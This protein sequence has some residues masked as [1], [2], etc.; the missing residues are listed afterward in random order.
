MDLVVSPI[1]L[2]IVVAAFAYVVNALTLW[3]SAHQAK[4]NDTDYRKVL[5]ELFKKSKMD[6]VVS[7]I[8]VAIVVAASAY[9][10]NTLTLWESAHQAKENDT[11][12]M[13]CEEVAYGTATASEVCIRN[14]T[15]AGKYH[16][17]TTSLF[18]VKTE[19]L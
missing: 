11:V 15:Y 16:D 18:P 2:A 7:P 14:R 4:E 12:Y 3:E 8:F 9:V 19:Q 1:F 10:V 13:I 17:R 6:L 5:A